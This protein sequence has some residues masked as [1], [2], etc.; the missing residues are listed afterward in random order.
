MRKKSSHPACRSASAPL[1]SCKFTIREAAHSKEEHLHGTVVSQ[2]KNAG[3]I[4]SS[5]TDVNVNTVVPRSRSYHTFCAE[6]ALT[7]A[8][9]LAA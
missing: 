8:E 4:A 3:R 7:A 2:P 9:E 6:Y 5:D 1:Y